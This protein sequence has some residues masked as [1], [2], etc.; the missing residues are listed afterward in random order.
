[1]DG[2]GRCGVARS[3]EALISMIAGPFQLRFPDGRS[4]RKHSNTSQG[5]DDEAQIHKT[6]YEKGAAEVRRHGRVICTGAMITGLSFPPS[7][8]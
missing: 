1:M 8:P 4:G 5:D 7:T 6:G 2:R 3:E